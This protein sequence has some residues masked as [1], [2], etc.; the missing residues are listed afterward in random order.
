MPKDLHCPTPTIF[1]PYFSQQ[2]NTNVWLKMECYQPTGAFKIRGLGRLCNYYHQTGTNHFVSSSGG[3]A[4]LAV[5]FAGRELKSKVD[6]F[7]PVTTPQVYIDAIKAEHA[8][9]H[10]VG[11]VWDKTNKIAKKFASENNAAFIPPFDH[12]LIFA[13]H[14]TIIQEVAKYDLR[15]DAVVLAVGGGGLCC[16]VLEGMHQFGWYDAP[17]FTVETEGTASFAKSCASNKHLTLDKVEGI[18]LTLGA[19]RVANAL[20]HWRNKHQLIPLTVKDQDTIDA[21]KLFLIKHRVFLE[22]ASGAAI[23][24]LSVHQQRFLNYKNI[25]VIVCG[26]AGVDATLISKT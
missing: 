10:L 23:A 7:M 21:I 14:A 16:G 12:P 11:D 25:L 24:A 13:G 18:A 26:G 22:P 20:W 17:V 1:S 5:A 3:N 8:S 6:V 9:V 15:P 19:K 2:L 4:G